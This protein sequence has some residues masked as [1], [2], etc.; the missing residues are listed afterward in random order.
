MPTD[1]AI[2]NIVDG[3]GR[4]C[5]TSVNTQV[6]TAANFDATMAAVN[7]VGNAID[8]LI[9][10]NIKS[11]NLQHTN[12]L[13]AVIPGDQDIM[14]GRKWSVTCQ[15]LGST[16][17]FVIQ[18]PTAEMDTE[19]GPDADSSGNALLDST[20]WSAFATAMNAG[21]IKGPAGGAVIVIK[22]RLV[23]RRA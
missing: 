1:R 11:I 18:L 6:V 15:D 16:R 7:A 14:R 22:G 17:T 23:T 10:G 8:D 13:T 9:D 21:A 3:M 12:Y 5:K 4:A 19:A 2:F 20:S